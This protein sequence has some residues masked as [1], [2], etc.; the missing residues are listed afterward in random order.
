MVIRDL[1]LEKYRVEC[2]MH[3]HTV[4]KR[5]SAYDTLL[6]VRAFADMHI[7]IGHKLF[8]ESLSM[9]SMERWIRCENPD[10]EDLST[11]MEK[12]SINQIN[13]EQ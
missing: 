10:E 4:L 5:I 2:C 3:L 11:E 8:L 6:Y 1:S 13:K 12:Y 9:H 7:A